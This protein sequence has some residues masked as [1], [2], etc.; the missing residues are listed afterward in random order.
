MP[1]SLFW[2]RVPLLNKRVA[3]EDVSIGGLFWSKNRWPWFTW[4]FRKNGGSP[5]A[6]ED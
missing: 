3:Q 5:A 4:W 1:F 2:G 6:E